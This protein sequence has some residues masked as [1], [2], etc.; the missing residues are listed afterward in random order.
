MIN[1]VSS[2]G[3]E[4]GVAC[5]VC[6][7]R[8][9]VVLDVFPGHSAFGKAWPCPRCSGDKRPGV[10]AAACGLP[11]KLKPWTFDKVARHAGNAAAYDAALERAHR[12]R[13]FLTLVGA[14]GVGKSILQA[15]IINKCLSASVPALYTT[16]ADLLDYVRATFRP[17]SVEGYEDRW[18][19]LKSVRVLCLDEVDRFNPSDWAVEKFFQ[20][21]S[22]RYD[23]GLDRL[24][25][26]ATNAS[27]DTF[28]D[29][30][31]SRM[32]D[33]KCGLFE[34]TGMD[35]RLCAR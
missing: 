30:L 8:G 34:L 11:D 23:Y 13:E 20:L 19:R 22:T 6:K 27:I 29:Y 33:R 2:I 10:L 18:E 15:S 3:W 16:T 4:S 1:D 26:L 21:I 9:F 12:P 28:P 14:T 7:D 17:N 35:V 24:T 31:Q 32:R 5:E 25:C